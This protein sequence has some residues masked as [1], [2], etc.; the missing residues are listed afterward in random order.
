[1]LGS[2]K[3][4]LG[5]ASTAFPWHLAHGSIISISHVVLQNQP[6]F[7]NHLSLVQFLLLD[8]GLA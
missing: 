5:M 2:K 1:M 7:M 8:H 4:Q 6:I 3:A